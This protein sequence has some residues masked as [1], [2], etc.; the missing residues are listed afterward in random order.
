MTVCKEDSVVLVDF[1]EVPLESTT[2]RVLG[3]PGLDKPPPPDKA[4]SSKILFI[5]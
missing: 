1:K 4:S 5:P 2:T 3:V